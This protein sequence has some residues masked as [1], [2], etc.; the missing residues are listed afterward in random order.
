MKYSEERIRSVIGLITGAL[1]IWAGT[2]VASTNI[3][4]ALLMI[5]V[6]AITLVLALRM[7]LGDR[8]GGERLEST[9]E[10]TT[11]HFDYL[12]WTAL[13]VPMLL[14]VGLAIVAITGVLTSK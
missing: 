1:F 4:M 12:I 10:L 14:V 2:R 6:G 11:P 3:P 8:A 13:I 9:G 7:T 5:A